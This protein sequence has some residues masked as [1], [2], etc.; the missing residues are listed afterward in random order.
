[1]MEENDTGDIDVLLASR[2]N[3]A[4]LEYNCDEGNEEGEY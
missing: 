3:R 4:D 2:D 1:M